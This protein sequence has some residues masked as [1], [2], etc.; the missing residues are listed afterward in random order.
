[1]EGCGLTSYQDIC[2][3]AVA[4]IEAHKMSAASGLMYEERPLVNIDRGFDA[5]FDRGETQRAGGFC[6]TQVQ[7]SES[8]FT[9]N[10]TTF[11][12]ESQHCEASGCRHL[13]RPIFT[14]RTVHRPMLDVRRAHTAPNR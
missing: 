9:A 6:A 8:F 12:H 10:A 1:M 5:G 13:K 3:S 7:R 2:L 4:N 11:D 14:R